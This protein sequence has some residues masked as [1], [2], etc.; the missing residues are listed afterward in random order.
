MEQQID[1]CGT[2]SVL[3]WTAGV[4]LLIQYILY[5]IIECMEVVECN[6]DMKLLNCASLNLIMYS[7]TLPSNKEFIQAR[8]LIAVR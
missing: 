8:W 5:H 7:Q 6:W 4:N 2:L 1:T 3:Q